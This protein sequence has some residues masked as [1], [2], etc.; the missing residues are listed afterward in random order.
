MTYVY[1]RCI[2]WQQYHP[3]IDTQKIDI[4]K[5]AIG[6]LMTVLTTLALLP[7]AE[8]RPFHSPWILHLLPRAGLLVLALIIRRRLF[9]QAFP[10]PKVC[11]D[12]VGGGTFF[13]FQSCAPSWGYDRPFGQCFE[14]SQDLTGRSES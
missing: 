4:R 13:V 8:S 5:A 12:C 11:Q 10:E 1:T 3:A 7:S 6:A 14:P 9:V 2:R